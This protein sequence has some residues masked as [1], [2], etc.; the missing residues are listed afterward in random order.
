MERIKLLIGVAWL[1]AASTLLFS[2]GQ[3][4]AAAADGAIE[5]LSE[6]L[7]PFFHFQIKDDQL[8]LDRDAREAA[9]DGLRQQALDPLKKNIERSDQLAA[10]M[11]ETLK[12]EAKDSAAYKQALM[13]MTQQQQLKAYVKR[14]DDM[15]AAYFLFSDLQRRAVA[16]FGMV[17]NSRGSPMRFGDRSFSQSFQSNAVSMQV[18][19]SQNSERIQIE[20]TTTPRSLYFSSDE[21]DGFR[22][23]LTTA[24]NDLIVLQQHPD[25]FAVLTIRNGKVFSESAE[26][27][28]GFVK[29]NR[30][31]MTSFVF[32]ALA[33]VGIR[34]APPIYELPVRDAAMTLL[35]YAAGADVDTEKLIADLT[36]ENREA[37]ERAKNTLIANYEQFQSVVKAQL[38][39]DSLPTEKR[40][41][42]ER[43]VDL[44]QITS[45][46]RGIVAT[47]DLLNDPAYL[48]SLL[49]DADP[50]DFVRIVR[51][52]EK[53]S[54]QKLGTNPAAWKAWVKENR[55][56]SQGKMPPE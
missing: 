8:V 44:Q 18:T 5:R 39:M 22:L 31:L 11:E 27:F 46:A 21:L 26:S 15:P 47:F 28:L 24:D 50:R 30:E 54:G 33:K 53:V 16:Q 49:D 38:Q 13:Q 48:V 20:E 35:Q 14:M 25:S 36:S 51:R 6:S 37:C 19:A 42:L 40:R 23:E 7:A 9:A 34:P 17:N 3:Q 41:Q 45:E 32:P 4:N 29:E 12:K 2:L 10:K 52:L 43:L 56:E 55:A 1:C